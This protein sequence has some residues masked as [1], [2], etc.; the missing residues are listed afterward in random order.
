MDSCGIHVTQFLNG[1]TTYIQN[2]TIKY[3]TYSITTVYDGENKEPVHT[4]HIKGNKLIGKIPYYRIENGASESS[5]I[6]T[7]NTDGN[8]QPLSIV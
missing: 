5:V 4:F 7:G 3:L 2:N 8:R 1:H 6:F